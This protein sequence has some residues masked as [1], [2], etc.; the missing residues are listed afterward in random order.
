MSQALAVNHVTV[1][2]DGIARIDG[3]RFKVLHLAMAVRGGTE[4]PQQLRRAF[5]QLTMAQICSALACYYDNQAAF[6][7]QVDEDL[8]ASMAD[9]SEAPETAGRAK[10][11]DRGLRP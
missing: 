10:L 1:A 11:R 6:D 4:S 8:A 7:L 2:A 5:P 3:T 9:R